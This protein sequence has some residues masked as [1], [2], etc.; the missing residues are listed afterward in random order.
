MVNVVLKALTVLASTLEDIILLA[1]PSFRTVTHGK[2]SVFLIWLLSLQCTGHIFGDCF[3]MIRVSLYVMII[4]FPQYLFSLAQSLVSYWKCHPLLRS[5]LFTN[6]K[7][8]LLFEGCVFSYN[9][10]RVILQIVE[11]YLFPVDKTDWRAPMSSWCQWWCLCFDFLNYLT[12]KSGFFQ[13]G[14]SSGM[15]LK[16]LA[17]LSFSQLCSSQ[18]FFHL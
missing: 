2:I 13:R 8:A 5:D 17:K 18:F 4:C 6:A 12:S 7:S 1:S 11:N 14:A 15:S 9:N 10:V 16:P 3:Q